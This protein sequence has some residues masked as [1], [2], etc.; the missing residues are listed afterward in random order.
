LASETHNHDAWSTLP[1]PELNPLINPILGEN[2]GRWAEVYFTSPP[3][4]RE[5]AVLELLHE[6]EGGNSASPRVAPPTP[7]VQS[8]KSKDSLEPAFQPNSGQANPRMDEVEPMNVRCRSCG[9]QN[10]A[11]NKFCGMCGAQLGDQGATADLRKADL[12]AQNYAQPERS[13]FVQRPESPFHRS[14]YVSTTNKLSLFQ[15]GDEFD[16][17]DDNG[18][19]VPSSGSYR[20]YIGVA[21]A[22]IICALAYMA[23]RGG[24]GLQ[25]SHMVRQAPPS[26]TNEPERHATPA[27]TKSDA[28]DQ[29][30]A[31]SAPPTAPADPVSKSVSHESSAKTTPPETARSA[32]LTTAEKNP[33]VESLAGSEELATAQGYLKGTN[34]RGRDS[35]EA[36]RWLWKSIAKHNAEATLLLSD[37]YLR[38]DGV[39]KSCDQ[40]RVLL[41]TAARK[42]MKE[43]G[44]R[45]RHLEAFGCR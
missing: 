10:R 8:S 21:L 2:M 38:G 16:Y 36:A 35:A 7:V 42:G 1:L 20:V 3:E 32:P 29:K 44:E 25:D 34:G 37:L 11:S 4:R 30:A 45:L 12:R 27:P 43:A 19:E 15:S 5:Q 40:A 18:Y 23:W 39:S 24:L 22:I 13:E 6:L 14:D 26:V 33:Q 9:R 31:V 17:G 28:A 41:D